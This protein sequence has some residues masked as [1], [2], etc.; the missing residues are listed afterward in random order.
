M[1]LDGRV[2]VVTGGSSGIGRAV[3]L[4]LARA[5]ATVAVCFRNG[6][7]GA[8]GT[9]DEIADAGGPA[10]TVHGFDVTDYSEVGTAV[11][12]IVK[13]H[14]RVDILVNNAGVGDASA[15]VPMNPPEEWTDSVRTNLF[16]A[17]HCVK[18]VSLHMLVARSG[19]IVNVASIA[20]LTGIPGLSGYGASKAGLIGMTRSLSREF[21]PHGIRV[22]AV[23]PGYTA[24]TGMVTRIDQDRLAE[25]TSR[26]ALGRLAEPREVADAAVFLASDA[27][28][29]ITGQTLVVDGGLT[30]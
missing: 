14:G 29:Y 11:A 26:V 16:G 12:E 24:D 25:L 27:S 1:D 28:T 9:A 10:A 7:D 18:A 17:F 3:C 19:V 30:A 2:A 21:A 20:G 4:G 5:G 13:A 6:K 22:N 15:V 8:Q 23:A